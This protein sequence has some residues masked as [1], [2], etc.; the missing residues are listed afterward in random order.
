M[1]NQLKTIEVYNQ[2]VN[3]Y[4][5]KFMHF[6]LYDDTFDF[7]LDLIPK[8]SNMLELGCGPGNVI[9]YFLEKRPDLDILGIDLAPEM[10]RKAKEINP[11][12]RFN[13]LDIRNAAQIDQEF[14]VVMAAFCL[15]YLSFDDL[16]VFFANIKKLTK[17]NGLVYLSCMEGT[18]ERS[19]FEKTSFTGESEIYIYYHQRET[20]ESYLSKNG[21]VV[22][23]FYTKDYPET[24]GTV[25]TDL[26]YVAK[27]NN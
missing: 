9:K 11:Q 17:Q 21:F 2:Y 25:T 5:R 8:N 27:R 26:I 16:D 15:P 19:G 18:R 4:V 1:D 7:L 23:K 12:A 22:E 13:L 10:L 24:D 3:E 14:S 20:I 6:D